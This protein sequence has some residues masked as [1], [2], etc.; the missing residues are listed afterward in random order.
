[1]SRNALLLSLAA[2]SGTVAPAAVEAVPVRAIPGLESITFWERTGG[3][4]PTPSTFTVSSSQ[5][6]ARL[7]DPLGGANNDIQGVVGLEFYD[8]F[9]SNADGSFNLDGEFLSIEGTFGAQS[10]AGGGLNLAEIG[11][12]F[13]AAPGEFGN[14]VAS[15]VALGDNA[16]P[17]TVGNAIDGD[18]LTHTTMGNT[19]NQAQRLRVTLGFLSSSGPPPGTLPEPASLALL[20]GGLA[21]L[22]LARR[23]RKAARALAP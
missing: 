11:L 19:V 8:V 1:M 15:F 10:P 18:L 9:Y 13:S 20:G 14:F 17:G 5:L 3:T 23:P 7:S 12:N 16:S 21:A 4:A 2:L 6:T 22:W